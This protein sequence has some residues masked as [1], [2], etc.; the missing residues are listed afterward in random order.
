MS[1]TGRR[2]GQNICELAFKRRAKAVISFASA[3]FII[4]LPFQLV[5]IF[6]NFLKQLPSTNSSGPQFALNMPPMFYIFFAVL[7][8]GLAANGLVLWKQANC[9][10]QG[11]QGEESTG[12]ELS[13]L[14]QKGWCIEYGMQLNNKLGDADIVCISPQGKAYVIDVKSHQGKVTTDGKQLYRRVGNQNSSFEK[15]FVDQVMKQAL[16]VKKQKNLKF[17]TPILAFSRAKVALPADN[18]RKVYVVEK[19]KLVALLQTLG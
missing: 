15:D 7:A 12:L 18:L 19:A 6:E 16:Q 4:F 2:A 11:A 10:V 9:A 14:E 3:G 5:R 13:Q 17:V 8:L 1:A